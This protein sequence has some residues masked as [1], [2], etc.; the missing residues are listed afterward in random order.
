[1]VLIAYAQKLSLNAHAHLFRDNRAVCQMRFEECGGSMVECLTQD[2][3]CVI[4]L[5]PLL[6]A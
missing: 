5:D 3:G 4:E 2:L 1:M 6:S